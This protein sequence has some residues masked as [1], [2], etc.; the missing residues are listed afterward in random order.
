M[1]EVFAARHDGLEA[2]SARFDKLVYAL[3]QRNITLMKEVVDTFP[4]EP[5]PLVFDLHRRGD[6]FD[7]VI[8]LCNSR[9]SFECPIFRNHVNALYKREAT[10]FSWLI[11]D[12]RDLCDL[13]GHAWFAGA[14]V[15]RNQLQEEVERFV[16]QVRLETT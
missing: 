1:A 14:R 10:R 6:G 4:A 3:P 2:F 11:P 9:A 16:E 8:T 7:Y 12:F 13:T 15:I 5:P